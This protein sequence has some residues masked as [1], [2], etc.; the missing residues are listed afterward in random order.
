M[1]MFAAKSCGRRNSRWGNEA[2]PICF[3]EYYLVVCLLEMVATQS[4]LG[5]RNFMNE[6][7]QIHDNAGLLGLTMTN[8]PT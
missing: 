7:N 3:V 4:L 5:A 1:R 8:N 6:D 2:L